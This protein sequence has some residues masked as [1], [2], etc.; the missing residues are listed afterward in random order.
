MEQRYLFLVLLLTQIQQP[1]L[2]QLYPLQ[3]RHQWL[4]QQ[5]VLVLLNLFIAQ[6]QNQGILISILHSQIHF[7]V[8]VKFQITLLQV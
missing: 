6:I 1:H 8:L 2:I 5:I 4:A 7:Y 3:V